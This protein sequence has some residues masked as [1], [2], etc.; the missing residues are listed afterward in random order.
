V[1]ARVPLLA[2]VTPEGNEPLS[3]KVMGVSPVAVTEKVPAVFSAKVVDAAEV[4]DGPVAVTVK[5]KD[6]VEVLALASV[7]VMVIG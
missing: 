6:W 1:P 4:I 2:R 3:V 5:V 7:A